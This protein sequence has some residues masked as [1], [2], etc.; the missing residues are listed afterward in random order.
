MVAVSTLLLKV[1]PALKFEQPAPSLVQLHFEDLQ[2][3]DFLGFS[4]Q[5]IP[6]SDQSDHGFSFSPLPLCF[7]QNFHFPSYQSG[8]QQVDSL[9]PLFTRLN[10]PSFFRL[11]FFIRCFNPWLTWWPLL[12]PIQ[13][14]HVLHWR[15]QSW[16]Q[17]SDAGQVQDRNLN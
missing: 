17:H 15:A 5:P 11:I 1:G 8:R 14:I 9:I 16:T 3:W 7:N 13:Y 4:W 6:V 10:K 2:R 12:H